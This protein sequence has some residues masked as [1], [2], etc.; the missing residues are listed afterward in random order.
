MRDL[1]L[2]AMLAFVAGLTTRSTIIGIMTW[3]WVSLMSPQREVYGFLANFE[4]NLYVALFT[5]MCWVASRERKI[6]PLN[7]VTGALALFGIWMSVT[8]VFALAPDHSTPLY[9]RTLKTMV[10]ALGV[11]TLANTPARIQATVWALVLSVGYYGIRGGGFV[12]LTGGQNKVFGPEGTMIED[13]NLLGIALVALL[14]F[15]NYLRVT[16]RLKMVKLACLGA[17]VVTTLAIIGTYSRGAFVALGVLLALSAVRSRWGVALIMV[18]A[19]GVVAVPTALPSVMPES[20]VQRM[21]SIQSFE[22][23]ASFAGRVAAWKTSMEIARQRPLTGGGFAS[24]EVNDVVD[25]FHPPG[26]LTRG[27]AAHSIYFQ[28]L[29]DHGFV[30]FALY[31]AMVGFGLLNTFKVVVITRT[32]PDLYWANN[33]ARMIQLSIFGFLVGG[34]A[35]SAAYYDFYLIIFCLSAV[36]MDYVHREV[37]GLN[38]GRAPAWRRS[39]PK[40]AAAL[41]QHGKALE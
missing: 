36:L 11:A 2:L 9:V 20:W 8:T 40:A 1:I 18:G 37:H 15:W 38:T 12:L 3:M 28:V 32:R 39:Q 21:Q 27:L 17:L 22:Q 41:P 5:V 7:G 24:T 10:L 34:A 16:S 23:D 31:A 4:I 26:G 33:L 35:L 29:G 19:I 13:N 25:R 6:F 14:P 30:G